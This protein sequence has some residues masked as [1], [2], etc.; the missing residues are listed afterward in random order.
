MFH[1]LTLHARKSAS[2]DLHFRY[3][4]PDSATIVLSGRNESQDSVRIVLSKT[5]RKY[6]LHEGR[7]R[8]IR[9]N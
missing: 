2:P 4:R 7:R 9:I 3:T 1:E 6:L 8:P 5:D